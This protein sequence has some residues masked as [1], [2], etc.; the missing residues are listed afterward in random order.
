LSLIPC[1]GKIS[2]HEFDVA[3]GLSSEDEID[4]P[5]PSKRSAGGASDDGEE[6]EGEGQARAAQAQKKA[7]KL[8]GKE[9]GAKKP[10][11]VAAAA[12]APAVAGQRLQTYLEQKK[13]RKTRKLRK[14]VGTGG[15]GAEAS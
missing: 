10:G 7:P 9:R 5:G 3:T 6:S 2:D 12:A 14:G 15:V 4:A 11:S 13:K 1:R 8:V